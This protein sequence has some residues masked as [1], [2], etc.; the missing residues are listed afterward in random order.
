MANTKGPQPIFD[1][2]VKVIERLSNTKFDPKSAEPFDLKQMRKKEA[3]LAAAEIASQR[4]NKRKTWIDDIHKEGLVDSRFKFETII[5]DD[6]NRIAIQ[7]AQGFCGSCVES[8]NESED[9]AVCLLVRGGEGSGKTVIAN[10]I[11]NKWLELTGHI[12]NIL[13]MDDIRK[14]CLY[15]QNEIRQERL[16][17]GDKWDS[18][19][20]ISLLI[21]DGL[22][23][24]KEQLSAFDQK[25]FSSLLRIRQQKR[26]PLVIT[27]QLD[28][29]AL[30][31]AIGDYCFESIKEYSVMATALYGGSRRAPIVFNG[32]RL[33]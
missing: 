30:H 14:A 22:C 12:V 2:L 26:L 29:A 33:M 21:I 20:S 9:T 19:C 11:A 32:R 31:Q 4:K 13:S 17:R 18:F 10:A 5:Q 8:I 1:D 16:D 7:T 23:A 25:I 24:N 6:L 27:T 28:Y 3:Q 15:S